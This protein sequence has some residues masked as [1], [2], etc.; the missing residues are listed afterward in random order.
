FLFINKLS[1]EHIAHYQCLSS[2]KNQ[3]SSIDFN[4]TRLNLLTH[5]F[6]LED[7]SNIRIE[8]L[9]SIN[10][11]KL[12][13]NILINCSLSDGTPGQWRINKQ[14]NGIIINNSYLKIPKFSTEHFNLYYCVNNSTQK[15]LSL[16]E[17]L[18]DSITNYIQTN[19][20]FIE[21]IQGKYIGD[22]IT[23]ICR[24][25]QDI[26]QGKVV[27][28][29]IPIR[30]NHFYIRGPRLEFRPFQVEHHNQY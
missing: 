24:I 29:N 2:Y 15:I 7:T 19:D 20:S 16:S 4:I 6:P 30:S 13:G 3:Q 11:M 9:S 26:S 22:N 10:Q 18:F 21:M 5:V 14:I 17:I 23:L 1:R 12:N 8:F 25:G 27:W 28:S